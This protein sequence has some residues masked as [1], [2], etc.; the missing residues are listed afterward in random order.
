MKPDD[1]LPHVLP[2]LLN[3]DPFIRLHWIAVAVSGTIIVV[4]GVLAFFGALALSSGCH[5]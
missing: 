2:P 3:R 4:L 1:A 5:P